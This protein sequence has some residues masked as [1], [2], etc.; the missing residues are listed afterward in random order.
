MAYFRSLI[1]NKSYRSSRC[2][3][4]L[5]EIEGKDGNMLLYIFN[6]YTRT[7]I[8]VSN[9]IFYENLDISYFKNIFQIIKNT[10]IHFTI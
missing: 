4:T 10:H 5:T 9:V 2:N 8:C 3:K 6:A 7:I 1:T